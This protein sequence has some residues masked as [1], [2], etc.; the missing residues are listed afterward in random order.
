MDPPFILVPLYIYPLEGAW[1]PLL[2]VARDH[3]AVQFTAI[4]NPNSGPGATALPDASYVA[5]LRTLSGI[6]NIRPLGY[7]HC[8]YGKRP[9]GVVKSE[10][11]VYRGWNA[12]F[13]LD[14]VFFDEAPSDPSYVEYMASLSEHTK[15]TWQAGLGHAGIT[16]YNPGVV[17]ERAYFQHADYVVAFEQSEEHWRRYFAEQGL[18][19]IAVEMR[20]KT[21]AIV[22]SCR[23]KE[24]RAE[25][26]ARQVRAF[27]LSGVYLTEQMGGGY[28]Q[29]PVTLARQADILAE[30]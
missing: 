23:A 4:I 20:R 7:V 22:H 2:Q 6:P 24:G 14:G 15:T 28:T 12:E 25:V 18:P 16:I 19:Q 29:W 30:S 8:S 13:R 11:D 21:V 3:P 10:I 17:V 27:G 9:I 1:E 26:L 5:A